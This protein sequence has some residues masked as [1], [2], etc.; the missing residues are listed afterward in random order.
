MKEGRDK[1]SG[2]AEKRRFLVAG[3][4]NRE[5]ATA[6]PE[7]QNGGPSRSKRRSK[8]GSPVGRGGVPSLCRHTH[9]EAF[10]NKT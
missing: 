9:G 4:P 2:G 8:L 5:S 10:K 6:A 7:S 1:G 3:P